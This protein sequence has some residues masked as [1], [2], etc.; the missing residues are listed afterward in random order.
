MKKLG[1]IFFVFLIGFLASCN[2]NKLEVNL[3][4]LR[5]P[6][7]AMLAKQ[8]GLFDEKFGSLGYQV[9][10]FYFDSGVDANKA[11]ISGDI[12]FATMGNINAIIALGKNLDAELVWIHETL[13]AVEAL[14]VKNSAHIYEINDLSGKTIATTFASTSHYILLNVLKEAGIEDEVQLLNMKT[15]EIVAAWNRGDIDAAYTW[16]PSL[17]MLLDDDGTVLVSSADMIEK[18]YMTA[19]VELARKS[20][21]NEHPELIQ[22]YIECMNEAYLY[23]NANR[24]E[25]INMLASEIE[26]DVEEITIEVD[27]SIWTSLLDMQN[28]TFINGYVDTMI[29]QCV[30]LEEQD[31]LTRAITREEMVLFLNNSYALEVNNEKIN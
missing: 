15:S 7:D 31:F 9:N 6:N 17:G 30:F 18:G 25:A 23:F 29:S 27:G 21:A 19:N 14:A 10:Y 22:T 11:I 24:T 2:N 12:D 20:F 28:S 26:L 5:V 16:Q 1:I 3:G 4:L 13:G 8:M